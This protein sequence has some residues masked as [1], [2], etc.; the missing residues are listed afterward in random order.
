MHIVLWK[1]R[2]QEACKEKKKK[3]KKKSLDLD[4]FTELSLNIVK[5]EKKKRRKRFIPLEEELFCCIFSV[6]REKTK[7]D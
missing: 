2:D 7:Y 1:K 6:G 3:K 5:K 4:D